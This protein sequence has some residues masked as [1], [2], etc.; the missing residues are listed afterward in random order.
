M[1]CGLLTD[2]PREKPVR[3]IEAHARHGERRH[4]DSERHYGGERHGSCTCRPGEVGVGCLV[5][6]LRAS[7]SISLGRERRYAA[8]A[9]VNTLGALG[10]GKEKSDKCIMLR[11]G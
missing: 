1:V 7:G 2:L 9:T 10:D 5:R 3:G 6:K 8:L 11:Q 4:D